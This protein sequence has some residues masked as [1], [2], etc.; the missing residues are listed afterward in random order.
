MR[1][2]V[3]G[4]G[5][6]ALAIARDAKA[7]GAPVAGTVRSAGKAERLRT[8][9]IDASVFDGEQASPAIGTALAEATHLLASIPPGKGDPVLAKYRDVILAAPNLRWIGYLSTVGVYG[10]YGGAWVSEG[11]TPHPGRGRSIERLATERAWQ[12]L[13]AERALP[14]AIFRIAGI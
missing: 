8:E 1:L 2:F 6:S 13:A 7:G 9:K 3:F 14:I 12:D 5:Y 10:D 11:T 4:V